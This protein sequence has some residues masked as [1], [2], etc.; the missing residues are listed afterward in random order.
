LDLFL[1]ASPI[2]KGLEKKQLEAKINELMKANSGPSQLTRIFA[3]K[4]QVTW[5]E[6]HP[7][8]DWAEFDRNGNCRNLANGKIWQH[9]Y[10]VNGDAIKII[11]PTNQFYFLFRCSGERLQCIKI[12]IKT[13][14]VL[15]Q[16]IGNP[17]E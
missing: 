11:N 6:G 13:G 4:W 8:W 10:Q 3:G 5:K 9:R 7:R 12:D 14:S 17:I 1:Q 16:G 2:S 15:D